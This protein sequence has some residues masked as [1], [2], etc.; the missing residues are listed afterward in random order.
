ML[1]IEM[2]SPTSCIV[3]VSDANVNVKGM[4]LYVVK[5]ADAN[6][7]EP[8]MLIDPDLATCIALRSKASTSPECR[9]HVNEK[10]MDANVDLVRLL[11]P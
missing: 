11:A 2:V 9:R 6:T 8:Y 4:P 1:P 7:L 5:I 10:E 3:G